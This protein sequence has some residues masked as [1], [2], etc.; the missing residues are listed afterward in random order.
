MAPLWYPHP[1]PLQPHA[2]SEKC[3][4]FPCE[5]DVYCA[6]TEPRVGMACCQAGLFQ[7]TGWGVGACLL[8]PAEGVRSR[9][10]VGRTDA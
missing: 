1:C 4:L 10:R 2:N 9:P 8:E 5:S 3:P 6:L 7:A